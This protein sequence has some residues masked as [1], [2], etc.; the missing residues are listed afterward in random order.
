MSKLL[1]II[2][3]QE[4]FFQS[5]RLADKREDFTYSLNEL[6]EAFR[7]MHQ[8]I[9]WVRQ[10]SKADLSDTYLALR[11]STQQ[12]TIEGTAGCE[13]L[14]ECVRASNEPEIIKKRYSAFFGTELDTF[15]EELK[16]RE[17]VIAGVNTHACIRVTAIDAYQR[18]FPLL[19]AQDCIDSYDEGCHNESFSYLVN[20]GIGVPQSNQEI[21]SALLRE[22]DIAADQRK[23]RKQN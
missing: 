8:P 19:L 22:L 2:D 14:R 16:P 10:V 1:L 17:I 12:W 9:V 3:V 6:V 13:L 7:Q 20:S 18:D 23:V 11:Q 15:L 5:G 4:D 21:L